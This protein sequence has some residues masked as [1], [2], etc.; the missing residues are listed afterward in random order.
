MIFDVAYEQEH[1]V[2]HGPASHRIMV[3]DATGNPL[4]RVVWFNTETMLAV[5]NEN[6]LAAIQVADYGF[7][8][9]AGNLKMLDEL[10]RCLPAD[11]CNRVRPADFVVEVGEPLV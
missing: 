11:Q 2:Q 1:G 10:L 4:K 8:Y 5:Q 9:Q 7:Y 3:F 6:G